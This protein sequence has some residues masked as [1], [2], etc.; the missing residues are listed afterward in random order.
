MHAIERISYRTLIIEL[1]TVWC[2][3]EAGEARPAEESGS[4]R[5][6]RMGSYGV[7]R[8]VAD[9]ENPMLTST[10]F[11]RPPPWLRAKS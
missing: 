6:M 10:S 3:Y 5:V 9:D 8:I 1:R 2:A 7:A 11:A 4:N